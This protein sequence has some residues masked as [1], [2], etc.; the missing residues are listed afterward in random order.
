MSRIHTHPFGNNFK[1][2]KDDDD[3]V[4]SHLTSFSRTLDETTKKVHPLL[5]FNLHLPNLKRSFPP[6][7]RD[8]GRSS[9]RQTKRFVGWRCCVSRE[10]N[11]IYN[12]K[13]KKKREPSTCY[14]LPVQVVFQLNYRQFW[15][16]WGGKQYISRHVTGPH[17]DYCLSLNNSLHR[18]IYKYSFSFFK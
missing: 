18:L 1:V 8:F 17:E 16:H 6:F 2:V 7:F 3:Q 14:F 12:S 10:N 11:Q 13:E 5:L 9:R 15:K 4:C